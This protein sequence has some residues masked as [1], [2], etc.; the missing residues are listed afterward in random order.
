M[1]F[2]GQVCQDGMY[3][4]MIEFTC[5]DKVKRETGYINLLR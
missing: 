1:K 5:G 3:V 4:W 2:K